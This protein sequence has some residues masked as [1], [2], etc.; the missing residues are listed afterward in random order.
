MKRISTAILWVAGLWAQGAPKDMCAPPPGSVA[1]SLPARLLAGQGRIQFPITTRSPEAQAFFNQGVAQMHSFWAVE[2][3][4]SFL[5]A[6]ALDPEAPMPQWGIAMVA[7]GDYR[8][9]FQLVRDTSAPRESKPAAPPRGGEARAIAAAKKAVELS[10]APGKASDLEKLYIAS[11]AARRD[12]SVADHDAAYTAGLRAI[13]AKYPGEVEARLYLALH[14]MSG[15][16]LPDRKPREGSLEAVEILRKLLTEAPDHPGVHHYV[17]HGW[18]GSSF[19]QEAWTSCRRYPELAD[20]I[21]HALHM[22]GHIWAQTGKW[23]EAVSSFEAAAANERKYMAADRLY[24]NG[25]H[26]HNVHFLAHS[27]AFQGRHD[28]AL[29]NARELLAMPETP[30]EEGQVDNFRTAYRQGWFA[31][32]LA[33]LYAEKWDAILDGA[34]LPVYDKKPRESAWRHYAVGVAYAAKGNAT[35]AK[36]EALAMDESL[37]QLQAKTGQTPEPLKVA[38]RELDGQVALARKKAGRAMR[39]LEAAMHSERALRYNEPPSYPRPVGLALGRAALAQGK[40]ALAETAFRQA[41]DR[42]PESVGAR[43]GLAETLRREGKAVA[44][45]L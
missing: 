4:R 43:D 16:S 45:G 8:P 39:I 30:R 27:Y 7:A 12:A 3:E 33:L 1:P 22:P 24:G 25:H 13:A 42:Y 44:A 29:E 17:I 35:A 18:E 5:Q 21:P 20:N 9:H 11:I 15:F 28:K 36:A 40:L 38:R 19:A 37:K 2:A 32:L 6:A 31:M 23:E 34:T 26:G 41:L 10:Q 14:L